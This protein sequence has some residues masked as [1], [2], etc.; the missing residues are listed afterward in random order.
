VL[1]RFTRRPAF[2]R[3]VAALGIG[4]CLLAI[5]WIDSLTGT[6]MSFVIFYLIP[7]AVTVAWMGRFAALLAALASVV[8]RFVADSRDPEAS[9]H[10]AWLWWN[11]F[12][13]FVVYLVIVWI[14]DALIRFHRQLE[15]RVRE[16]TAELEAEVRKRQEVQRQ[17]LDLSA[18]ERSA[19]GREL[20]DQL[21]QHLV[22]TA[23]AAQV[24]AQRL[25]TREENGGREARKIAELVEQGVAQTR[26]LAHGL[27][28]TQLEP[29]RLGAEF[30]E[31]CA[32]LRQQYPHTTCTSEIETRR[33]LADA[34]L[35]AQLFRIGQEAL[36]NALR[37]A[38]AS[39]VTLRLAEE[40]DALVLSVTD[41]G[42]GLPPPE[43]RGP[44]MGLSIMQHR[45][46]HLGTRL[47]IESAPGRGTCITCRVPLHAGAPKS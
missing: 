8:I 38:K 23:M 24:L 35:A 16:R 2:G 6:R 46:E 5:G 10:D 19:M 9:L 4:G 12:G 18:N 41:D 39:R 32:T 36:R 21:G 45:A 22:G 20:H 17:L 13:S 47:E 14:L 15:H 26:Q 25:N 43:A 30:E 34:G 28:L 27:L 7:V 3:S 42:A 40:D 1:A 37:H 33:A 29:A 44:G 31:L 11:S